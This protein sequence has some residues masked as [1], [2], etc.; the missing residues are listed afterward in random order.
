MKILITGGLGVLGAEVAHQSIAQGHKVAVL[1]IAENTAR[2]DPIRNE[3]ELIHADISENAKV[4][5]IFQK[6]KPEQVVHFAAVLG[7]VSE[8]EPEKSF[9]ANVAGTRNVF[10]AARLCGTRQALFAS[11]TGTFGA[12]G[13][14][15]PNDQSPQRPGIIYGWEKLYGEGLVSWY[16]NRGKLDCRG[17]RY[18]QVAG[19]SC[20]N[21]CWLWASGMIGDAILHG[22]HQSAGANPDSACGFLYIRDAGR[23]ALELLAA[24]ADRVS[25]TYNLNG[26]PGVVY[27][28]DLEA[29]LKQRYPGFSVTYAGPAGGRGEFRGYDDS[30]A[31]RDW[32]W[33]PEWSTLDAALDQ[34]ERDLR[35]LPER[36]AM[37]TKAH[38]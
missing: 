11:S 13:G 37:K 21:V 4:Q 34:F 25:G 12:A 23:A 33:K 10:E 9:H 29:A 30:R 32:N 35:E 15:F 22:R 3:V 24:P 19:P 5:A 16:R 20:D 36:F 28:S 18:S 8:E 38:S 27:A 2:I 31:C 14:A 26:L 7:P 6:I 17:L 1:D